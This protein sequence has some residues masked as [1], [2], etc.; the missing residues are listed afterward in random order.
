MSFAQASRLTSR[1][2]SCRNVAAGLLITGYLLID[3]LCNLVK[4][5]RAGRV[6]RRPA[7]LFVRAKIRAE[8]CFAA[9]AAPRPPSISEQ[10]RNHF[11]SDADVVVYTSSACKMNR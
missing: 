7:F 11:S 2:G 8:A 9:P 3:N 5:S 4:R 10:Q 1:W 6:G